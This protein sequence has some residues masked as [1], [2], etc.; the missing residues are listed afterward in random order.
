MF[1]TVVSNRTQDTSTS[2]V[3]QS[4][5]LSTI[6]GRLPTAWVLA[7]L[8]NEL[9]AHTKLYAYPVRRVVVRASSPSPLS[10]N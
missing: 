8:V 2:A 3:Q 10:L 6:Q 5:P 7:L 4:G 1:R 9:L